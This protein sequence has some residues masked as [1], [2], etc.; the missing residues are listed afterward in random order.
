MHQRG[1]Q[2]D[3]LIVTASNASQAAAYDTQLKLRRDLG[4]LAGIA[5]VLVVADPPRHRV[6]SGGS[7]VLCLCEALRRLGVSPDDPA[8]WLV[9]LQRIRILIVHAGG[10]SRRLPA[11][12]S[13]GK[14]FIPI[15]SENDSAISHTLFD[16]QIP[17]YIALPPPSVGS[18]Q[19]VITAGDVLLNFDPSA[20]RFS[21]TGITGLGSRAAPQ[22]AAKHGV[23]CIAPNGAADGGPVRLYLQKPTLIEQEQQQAIDRYGQSVL[24][25]GVIAFDAAAAVAML[26]ACGVGQQD[27]LHWTG[28]VGRAIELLGLDFYREICLR[29]GYRCHARTPSQQRP[30]QRIAMGRSIAGFTF[31][32]V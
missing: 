7:T 22:Q 28:A 17:A 16:R 10:D 24:D 32:P 14:I 2:W 27:Q 4:L 29:P 8:G 9:A 20:V 23:Y 6:G 1:Q 11:Y 25:I 18:G 3:F 26:Q 30:R 5:Q 12:G 21:A 13:C 19:I 31:Y 15:P